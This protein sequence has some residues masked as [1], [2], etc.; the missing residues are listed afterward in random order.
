M[1]LFRRIP[2]RGFSNARFR[3][4]YQ[5]VNTGQLDARFDDGAAVDAEAMKNA[6]LVGDR[7]APIKVLA[8]GELSKKL[9][10]TAHKFSKSAAAKI[11]A[12]GGEVKP[13]V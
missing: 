2:K 1:P 3:K 6:G 5:V 12:A 9:V 7:D 11:A 10:V 13:V 8:D 4:E